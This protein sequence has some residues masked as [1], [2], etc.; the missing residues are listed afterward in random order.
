MI[1][2]DVEDGFQIRLYIFAFINTRVSS[3]AP[4]H[5]LNQP[6]FET[7]GDNGHQKLNSDKIENKQAFLGKM[8]F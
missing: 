2:G 6:R 7:L 1:N 3:K 4:N 5:Q 8:F